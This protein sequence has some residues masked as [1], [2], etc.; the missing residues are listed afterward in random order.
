MQKLNHRLSRV[1]TGGRMRSFTQ[2]SLFL[3]QERV[4]SNIDRRVAANADQTLL[5]R[6]IKHVTLTKY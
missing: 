1:V 5:E 4:H 6:P 2:I 3:R